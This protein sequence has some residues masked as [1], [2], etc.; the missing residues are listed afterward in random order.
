MA[1]EVLPPTPSEP[2]GGAPPPGPTALPVA[3]E[4]EVR[5][6]FLDYSMSVIISRALPDVRDGLKPVHRRILYAM[7]QEGLVPGRP[8]SK[9]AGVVGE[10]LKH[11]HPHGDSA[12][13]DSMV[14][15]AQDFSLRYPLVDGQ[16][17][18][19][20]IDDDP[21]AAMRYCV[22]G[23]TRV[24]TPSG[25]VKIADLV[26]GA[27]PDSD[28]PVEL[29]VLDRL[30]RP[31]TASMLFH[32]GTHPTLR[33]ATREGF[34]LTGT[35]NHPVLCL[36]DVLGVPMLLWKLLDEVSAGD[37]VVI[38]RGPRRVESTLGDHDR[39]CALLSGAF[40][41]EGW[42]SE[43]RAGFNNT[44]GEFFRSVVSAYD[45]V[46]GGQ[47]YVYDRTLP[48]GRRIWELD[49]QDMTRLAASPL[50]TEIGLRSADK[51]VPEHIWRTGQASKRVFLQALATRPG[52]VKSRNALM[53]AAYDDQVYVDDRTI[54]SHIKRLR[55]KFKVTDDDFEMIE[56]LYGV[57]YRF[58]EG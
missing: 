7:Q 56:T 26:G 10:V 43:G 18:F 22:V 1:D 24:A 45:L 11:Y 23:D 13:Y 41:S 25:T 12:V 15:M 21:P 39:A 44:D 30:G 47:R 55:K 4:D 8:Y 38:H 28:T 49:I 54:D 5:R 42:A 32:S 53:D 31:V 29:A 14:R 16:G 37:R 51:R 27:E 19:G 40:V 57:G 50:G 2:A 36:V 48:S 58:K 20:S 17:N 35:S 46:V 52:V 6:S 3:I 34:E 9:S 33:I